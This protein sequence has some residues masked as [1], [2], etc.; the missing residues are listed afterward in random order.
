MLRPRLALV[1]VA[2]VGAF[3]G[4][5]ALAASHGTSHGT[6]H[7]VKKPAPRVQHRLPSNVHVP[8]H[9]HSARITSA[10]L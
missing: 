8:C 4:G 1:V 9:N 10:Q 6:S 3:G 2:G 7:P 5:A